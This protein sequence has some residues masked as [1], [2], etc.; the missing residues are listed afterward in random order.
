MYGFVESP[1][2]SEAVGQTL[3]ALR[4]LEG[5]LEADPRWARI[6]ETFDRFQAEFSG[7]S[8]EHMEKQCRFLGDGK[9]RLFELCECLDRD[10]QPA[11]TDR[12][13]RSLESA[14]CFRDG[15]LPD[16][17]VVLELALDAARDARRSHTAAS[18]LEPSAPPMSLSH[19]SIVAPPSR[20]PVSIGRPCA[21]LIEQARVQRHFYDDSCGTPAQ[22]QASPAYEEARKELFKLFQWLRLVLPDTGPDQD[23]DG[24][25]KRHAQSWVGS[26]HNFNQVRV[27]LFGAGKHAMHQLCLALEADPCAAR[28]RMACTHLREA[29]QTGELRSN[30]ITA[31][32]CALSA[33][34]AAKASD[35]TALPVAAK[36][37]NATA[38]P[39][40]A[41]AADATAL[42]M[43]DDAVLATILPRLGIEGL[44]QLHQQLIASIDRLIALMPPGVETAVREGLNARRE[45]WATPAATFDRRHAEML[46]GGQAVLT[47][48]ADVLDGLDFSQ[49]MEVVVCRERELCDAGQGTSAVASLAHVLVEAESVRSGEDNPHL[50]A[51]RRLFEAWARPKQG[52]ARLGARAVEDGL[53]VLGLHQ[54]D[55]VYDGPLPEI[56][57]VRS[58]AAWLA[59]LG[60]P[61]SGIEVH[62][63]ADVDRAELAA[64]LIGLKARCD[65]LIVADTI[66]L[67]I[68]ADRWL[69]RTPSGAQ[70]DVVG[71]LRAFGVAALHRLIERLGQPGDRI[72]KQAVLTKML[73]D[74]ATTE[75][76]AALLLRYDRYEVPQ[77]PKFATS[78]KEL[79]RMRRSVVER[80]VRRSATTLLE[81]MDSKSVNEAVGRECRRV[82]ELLGIPL[83]PWLASASGPSIGLIDLSAQ[84]LA[85][86]EDHVRRAVA[87]SQEDASTPDTPGV[88]TAGPRPNV[89]STAPPSVG[90]TGGAESTRRPVHPKLKRMIDELT[91]LANQYELDGEAMRNNLDRFLYGKPTGQPVDLVG[92]FAHFGLRRLEQELGNLNATAKPPFDDLEMLV[93]QLT[94]TDDPA[95]TLLARQRG[96]PSDFADRVWAEAVEE[97]VRK[98]GA[99][100]LRGIPESERE[101]LVW[102][103]SR[104]LMKLLG[105]PDNAVQHGQPEFHGL[106][107]A[108]PT[109]LASLDDACSQ[110]LMKA[111]LRRAAGALRE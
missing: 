38:L 80:E 97:Q 61:G 73:Q 40:A 34:V 17:G 103:E 57:P 10:R 71:N 64:A 29:F 7:D 58:N 62:P 1:D 91:A 5:L 36:A 16:A 13:L 87:R 6:R 45:G 75:D 66:G 86:L 83:A 81:G 33:V 11:T 50:E 90:A 88:A 107:H 67:D 65:D 52:K 85:R 35:A 89:D 109:N 41:K 26:A 92:N 96:E 43:T 20:A 27:R 99:Q 22:F 23:V 14:L 101:H 39:V 100:R 31:I 108:T 76:P 56:D 18:P 82:L 24:L 84:A 106:F 51:R 72:A 49:R 77:E 63:L 21:E 15:P 94:D 95:S 68:F 4:W 54:P 32:C 53:Q 19:L 44:H 30:S 102:Q 98:S 9:R 37:S 8:P 69:G 47:A 111:A 60:K 79:D 93:F 59:C 3:L 110:A 48:L 55:T 12:V 28:Q 46:I 74:M 104:F 70:E 42:P 2:F 78:Q 25:I 105:I